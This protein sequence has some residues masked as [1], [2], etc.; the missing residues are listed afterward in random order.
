MEGSIPDKSTLETLCRLCG[1]EEMNRMLHLSDTYSIGI[2]VTSSICHLLDSISA[3]LKV[4]EECEESMPKHICVSCFNTAVDIQAFVDSAI[5]FQKTT[6]SHLFPNAKLKELSDFPLDMPSQHF[7]QDNDILKCGSANEIP[8]NIDRDQDSCETAPFCNER[9]VK[10]G[11]WKSENNINSLQENT[12][13]PSVRDDSPN[14]DMGY[15]I[16]TKLI[17][18]CGLNQNC[19]A[20]T[21]IEI[22]NKNLITSE[23]DI[24]KC[25]KTVLHGDDKPQA[26]LQKK[27]QKQSEHVSPNCAS[28]NDTNISSRTNNAVKSYKD[29][30]VCEVQEVEIKSKVSKTCPTCGKVFLRQSQLKGHLASH[31]LARP[32]ECNICFLKFKYKRNLVEHSSIHNDVPTFMCSIC[33]LTFK[34]RSNLLKHERIHQN[35]TK[36]NFHCNLCKRS[37]SQSSHLKTHMRSVHGDCNGFACSQCSA[38]LQSKSSL[39]RHSSTVHAS[40]SKYSCPHCNKGFNNSQNYKGHIRSHTGDRPYCCTIC[41][42]TFTTSKAVSRHRLIHQGTKSHRCSQCGKAFLELCDLKRHV[43]RHLLKRMKYARKESNGRN[44]ENV[45]IAVSGM[46]ALNLMVLP[47]SFLFTESQQILNQAG[48]PADEIILPQKLEP[49]K[50]VTVEQ[51]AETSISQDSESRI[52]ESAVSVSKETHHLL[53]NEGENSLTPP[54]LM[55]SMQALSTP[56]VRSVPAIE[57]NDGIHPPEPVDEMPVTSIHPDTVLHSTGMDVPDSSNA[58]NVNSPNC[59]IVECESTSSNATMV[60]LSS[61]GATP[62]YMSVADHTDVIDDTR[63]QQSERVLSHSTW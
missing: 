18:D 35:V 2:S 25:N 24:S 9:I 34:Q 53:H 52:E 17:N 29:T 5:N 21:V 26:C 54:S 41:S 62:E 20:T 27:S 30:E 48:G 36:L 44:Q 50:N 14:N 7:C 3:L 51:V 11:E 56:E 19:S 15:S 4:Q 22:P 33:G 31:S 32:F 40:S 58:H 38:V 12:R 46:N 43:K 10:E 61:V 63:H 37:Y 16:L 23:Q 59:S 1:A 45:N 28:V 47:E 39:S 49:I 60:V 42:K 13:S 55:P 8:K 6:T 57:S